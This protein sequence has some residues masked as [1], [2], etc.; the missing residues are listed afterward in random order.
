MQVIDIAILY[1]KF[2]VKIAFY[3]IISQATLVNFSQR[4]P[5]KCYEFFHSR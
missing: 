2:R 5:L 1:Y 4:N 3:L